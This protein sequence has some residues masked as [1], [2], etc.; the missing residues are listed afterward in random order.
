MLSRRSSDA[1]EVPPQGQQDNPVNRPLKSSPTDLDRAF[2]A[3]SDPSRRAILDLL[4]EREEL[5]AGEIA[6]RFP[7]ISRPAVSKH[8]RI[9]R[10]AG[11]VEEQRDG[12]Y[13]FYRLP[14]AQLAEQVEGWLEPFRTAWQGKLQDLKRFVETG[15]TISNNEGMRKQ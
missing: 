5:T 4:R 1:G 12:R 3:L 7:A 15:E 14:A 6:E 10:E 9:L 8:L 11:L 2:G 13:V